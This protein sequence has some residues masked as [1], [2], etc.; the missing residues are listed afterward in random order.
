M[1]STTA[2]HYG[3][4]HSTTGFSELPD[5]IHDALD[6]I[7]RWMDD[8]H[9]T[10]DGR[11]FISYATN[12][13]QFTYGF[14]IGPPVDMQNCTTADI[15][16]DTAAAHVDMDALQESLDDARDQ[17]TGEMEEVIRDVFAH[18]ASVTLADSPS[19]V[20]ATGYTD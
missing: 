14:A 17:Y 7:S 16:N 20:I 4:A 11:E 13:G 19:L 8:E 6:G 15:T 3:Y 12:S 9:S 1:H 10:M 5:E 2:F 18:V